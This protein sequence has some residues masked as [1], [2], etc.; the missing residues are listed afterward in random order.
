MNNNDKEVTILLAPDAAC[1][2]GDDGLIWIRS[3]VE[4]AVAIVA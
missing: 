1:V 4:A 2:Q 3:G